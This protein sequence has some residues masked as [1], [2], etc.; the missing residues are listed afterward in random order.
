MIKQRSKRVT[1]STSGCHSVAA[2]VRKREV[3]R[4]PPLPF[5]SISTRA[6]DSLGH[7]CKKGPLCER[8]PHQVLGDDVILPINVRGSALVYGNDAK[9]KSFLVFAEH[10]AALKNELVS[11]RGTRTQPAS[12]DCG[13]V[14]ILQK[15][16]VPA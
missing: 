13:M 2:N 7:Q 1:C 4:S 5:R 6:L 12:R 9:Q 11:E 8:A 10:T 16:A 3:P 14:A 15:I